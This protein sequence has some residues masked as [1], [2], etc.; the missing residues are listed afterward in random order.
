KYGRTLDVLRAVK[1]MDAR[2]HTKSGIM[3]GLGETHQ[4]IVQTLC[5]LRS[6]GVSAVTIGQYLRPTTD[7]HLPVE[8]YIHPDQFKEY[9]RIGDEMGFL[10]VASGPFVRSSYNAQAFSEKLLADR[11]ARVGEPGGEQV[12]VR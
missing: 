4:E 1:N 11:L 7:R 6:V 3:L 9:E 12:A 10:F 2:I 8:A 5:D